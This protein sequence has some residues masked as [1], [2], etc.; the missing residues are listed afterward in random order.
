MSRLYLVRNARTEEGTGFKTDPRLDEVGREQAEGVVN[1]LGS[2]PP[3][4]ILTSPQRRA[5]ETAL[6]LARH[7]RAKPVIDESVTL[8]P[9]P[10]ADTGDV[11]AWLLAFMK[12]SWR[13]A[14]A[15]QTHW[16]ENCLAAIAR[17]AGDVVVVSHFIVVNMIVGAATGS[18]QV[19]V[20]QPDNG[21]ITILE[22]A[23]GK[24]SLVEL[25]RQAATRPL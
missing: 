8:M 11:E 9:L 25:G 20:F 22:A 2:L 23:N 1:R 16:R 17:Q 15:V 14:P 21:S 4:T 7:W 24:L 10:S 5:I 13:E 6:P 18:D 19:V 3:M 12:S